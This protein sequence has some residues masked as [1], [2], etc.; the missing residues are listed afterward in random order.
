MRRFFSIALIG[1]AVAG[2]STELAAQGRGG[3]G[4]GRAGVRDTARMRQMDSVRAARGEVERR[5]GPD[6]LRQRRLDSLRAAG[7]LDSNMR[8]GRGPGARGVGGRGQGVGPLMGRGGL[9]GIQLND[10]EK[11]AVKTISEKY[12]EEFKQ[13]RE[14]NQAAGA[15]RNEAARTQL[16]ALIERE[17]A[18]IRA[19]LTAGNQAKFDANLAKRPARG[20]NGA[21]AGRRPPRPPAQRDR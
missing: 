9:Q 20:A 15:A 8:G 17:Q 14:A 7:V 10:S 3:R 16:Q 19:A 11:A 4:Q 21:T 1:L 12:R 5:R 18:E 6:S 2:A 13:L